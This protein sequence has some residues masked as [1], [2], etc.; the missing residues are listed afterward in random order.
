MTVTEFAAAS[1]CR[2]HTVLHAITLG[3]LRAQKVGSRWQLDPSELENPL[4]TG[5][6]A[7]K[8]G[9]FRMAIGE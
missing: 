2:H 9:Q 6:R 5:R 7:G 1:G 4:W 3:R 8:P